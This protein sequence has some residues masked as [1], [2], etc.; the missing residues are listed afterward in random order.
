M[1]DG[2]EEKKTGYMYTYTSPLQKDPF[3]VIKGTFLILE[4]TMYKLQG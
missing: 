4:M 2:E 1:A 3:L